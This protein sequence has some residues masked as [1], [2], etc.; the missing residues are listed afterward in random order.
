MVVKKVFGIVAF[1]V[2]NIEYRSCDIMLWLYRT[3]V[4]P[5]LEYCVQFWLPFNE[6][7]A[8]KLER[9]QKTF[10]KMLLGL[11]GLSYRDRLNSLGFFSL[12]RQRLRVDLIEVY[13][14]LRGM[15]R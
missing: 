2:Q 12:V 8:V 10:T 13:K 14:I 6:K 1:I 4:K 9:V 7:D 11:K 15:D 3:M 5:L